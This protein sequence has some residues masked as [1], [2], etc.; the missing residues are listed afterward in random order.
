MPAAAIVTLVIVALV[1]AVLARYLL[2]IA[3]S[4]RD[5]SSTLKEVNTAVGKIPAKAEPV[6]PILESLKRDLTQAQGELEG[7]LAKKR[8]S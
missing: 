4:I 6:A 7:L 2:L 8:P 5:V 3:L 1:V